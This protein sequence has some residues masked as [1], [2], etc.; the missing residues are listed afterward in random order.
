MKNFNFKQPC[1]LFLSFTLQKRV[2]SVQ[3]LLVFTKCCFL[4]SFSHITPACSDLY[5]CLEM[6][7]FI[8]TRL[9]HSVIKLDES[10]DIHCINRKTLNTIFFHISG[11]LFFTRDNSNSR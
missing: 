4:T 11:H 6:Y 7:C 10:N 8:F 5:G 2:R 3:V 1:E 9:L